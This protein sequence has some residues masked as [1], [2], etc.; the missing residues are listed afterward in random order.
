MPVGGRGQSEL[1]TQD[2]LGLDDDL[3]KLSNQERMALQGQVAQANDG[4]LMLLFG[5]VLAPFTLG[6][7]LLFIAGGV[8]GVL[9]HVKGHRPVAQRPQ[10]PPT[11]RELLEALKPPHRAGKSTVS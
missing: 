4:C 8:S 11:I 6:L 9:D 7:S 5:L 2:I 1:F 3:N 10:H